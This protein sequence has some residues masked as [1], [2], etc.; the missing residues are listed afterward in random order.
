MKKEEL[1]QKVLEAVW[2]LKETAPLIHVIPNQVSASFTADTLRAA[3]ARPLMAT[4]REEIEEITSHADGLNV[5][6]GQPSKEKAETALLALQAAT[7]AGIPIVY[8]PVGAGA[9]RARLEWNCKILAAGWTGIVKGNTTEL[10]ALTTGTI[11]YSGVDAL[12]DDNLEC[13]TLPGFITAITGM[14]DLITDSQH[15]I[16]LPHKENI[17]PIVG[18]GCAA[19]ALCCAYAVVSRSNLIGT[20]TGLALMA[21]AQEKVRSLPYGSRKTVILDRINEPD[22]HSL[23]EWLYQSISLLN[24]EV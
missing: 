14:T 13:Q 5:N 3:G 20:I 9:S 24:P 7:Q 19:G 4:D 15:K 17:E 12:P 21:Y 18:T 10:S 23:E 16:Y 22:R 6:M 2:N 8:D 1:V 11:K